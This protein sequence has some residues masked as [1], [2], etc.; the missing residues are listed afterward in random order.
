MFVIPPSKAAE[1]EGRFEYELDGEAR[2]AP[3]LSLIDSEILA[4]F[5]TAVTRSDQKF[6]YIAALADH[7]DEVEAK[8]RRLHDDQLEAL[9]DAYDKASGVTSGESEASTGS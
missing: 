7:D 6:A 2:S 8:L 4:L 5:V 3:L 9:V 1:P